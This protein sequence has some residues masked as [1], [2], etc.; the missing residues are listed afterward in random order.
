MT[1]RVLSG[2]LHGKQALAQAF[3]ASWAGMDYSV[4]KLRAKTE[5]AHRAIRHERREAAEKH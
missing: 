5:T 3:A 2:L 4:L 1:L